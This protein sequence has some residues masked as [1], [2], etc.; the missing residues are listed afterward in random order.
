M[1]A[2]K[3]GAKDFELVVNHEDVYVKGTLDDEDKVYI[4]SRIEITAVGRPEWHR[5]E[6]KEK[7]FVD[8]ANC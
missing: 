3:A 1:A 4:E 6:K 7:F 8:L 2:Q 5:E